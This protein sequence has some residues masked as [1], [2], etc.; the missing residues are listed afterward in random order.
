MVYLFSA[1]NQDAAVT[2]L[3]LSSANR[4]ILSTLTDSNG[5]YTFRN[6]RSG[7]YLVRPN[8]TDTSFEP[9]SAMVRLGEESPSF[10]AAPVPVT[11]NGC[12]QSDKRKAIVSTDARAGALLTFGRALKKRYITVAAHTLDGTARTRFIS[13]MR[14]YEDRMDK[15]FTE[16]LRISEILPKIQRSCP[17]SAGF[18]PVK[19]KKRL[20][21]YREAVAQ[22]DTNVRKL[23]RKSRAM[24]SNFSADQGGKYQKRRKTLLRR[25]MRQT[26]KLPRATFDCSKAVQ[27]QA[28]S[29]QP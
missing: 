15:A 16:V 20:K 10:V 24:L 28:G 4:G 9:G 18:R 21:R 25:A 12:T 17:D 2:T 7:N 3:T 26:S 5:R 23:L 29:Q 27:G 8:L 22:I 6:V 11:A 1:P 13:L 14:T 19:F